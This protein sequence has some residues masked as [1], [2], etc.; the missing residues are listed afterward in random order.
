MNPLQ[1]QILST[2]YLALCITH[3]IGYNEA[4]KGTKCY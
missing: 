4:V 2:S 1:I 3:Q